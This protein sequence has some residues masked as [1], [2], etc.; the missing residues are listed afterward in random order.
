MAVWGNRGD[1]MG[2]I[3]K[4]GA[5][6]GGTG[7]DGNEPLRMVKTHNCAGFLAAFLEKR[8]LTKAA[9]AYMIF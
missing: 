4:G 3:L 1:I 9:G 7:W 5:P 6:A 2:N 8:E